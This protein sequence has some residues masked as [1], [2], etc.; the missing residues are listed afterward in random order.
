MTTTT[1]LPGEYVTRNH[2]ISGTGTYTGVPAAEHGT[3]TSGIAPDSHVGRTVQ[4]AP[5]RTRG[6]TTTGRIGLSRPFL[7]H[8]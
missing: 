3:S 8:H 7:A 2:A 6:R 4:S 5:R 1:T